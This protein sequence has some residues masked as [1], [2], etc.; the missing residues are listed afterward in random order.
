MKFT[1]SGLE[2]RR[3]TQ[4]LDGGLRTSGTTEDPPHPVVIEARS[5]NS[6]KSNKSSNGTDSSNSIC[7]IRRNGN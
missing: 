1:F 5:K 2:F 3:K 7:N 6:K 4:Y